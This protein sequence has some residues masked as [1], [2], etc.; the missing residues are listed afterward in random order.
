MMRKLETYRRKRDFGVTPEPP[1]TS[2]R[3]KRAAAA[4]TFMVHKHDATRLHYDLR[5]EMDGALASWAIPKGPS[6]DPQ[7]RRLAV[8][9]E[10]HPL[11]YGSFEGRIPEGQYGAGDSMIWDRGTYE[12]DPPGQAS[13]MRRKGHLYFELRGEKLKGRWHLVRT[14]YL[15]GETP[16]WLFF[17]SSKDEWA[18]KDYDV[19]TA[20]PES[21]VSGRRITR[22]PL[23]ARTLREHQLS[24]EE[25]LHRASAPPATPMLLAVSHG[26][27]TLRA[28]SHPAKPPRLSAA[29]ERAS[30]T[31]PVAEAVLAGNLESGGKRFVAT[32]LRWLD[33]EDL[34]RRAPSERRDLLESVLANATDIELAP[35][36]TT[37]LA[38]RPRA[39]R[40]APAK[41]F[42]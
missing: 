41:S 37:K 22:G 16:Q 15:P 17:K 1:P 26:K 25:L 39:P 7:E 30:S 34:R 5:L 3:A 18:R 12:T 2:S 6:F 23:R 40:S 14:R 42:A 35:R 36:E 38:R 4:P 28:C 19:V 31:L 33:G 8:Q 24:P 20:R 32:D 13:A 27:S 29:L 10:D 11:E 9:T 21:V